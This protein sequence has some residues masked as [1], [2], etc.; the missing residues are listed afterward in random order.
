MKLADTF[1]E[2]GL[3]FSTAF[4]GPFHPARTLEQVAPVFDDGGSIVTPG[5]V[6]HRNCSVQIDVA[7]TDMRQADG[8]IQT[9]VRFIVL[10]STLEGSLNT[11]ARIEVL[12]GPFVGVWM[13]SNLV[14]DP[15]SAG[16]VGTGRRG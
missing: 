8:F 15:V 7:N 14:R 12:D 3:A 16:W 2:I 5:T 11:A 13:V 9:D 10:A 1:A 6:A 4:G